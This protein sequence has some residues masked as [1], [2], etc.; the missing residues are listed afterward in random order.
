MTDRHFYEPA[1]GHGLSNDPLN[2]I[3]APRPI[4][5]IS[6]T[7]KA[8]VRKLAPYSFFNV[9]NYRPPLTQLS[10]S[11]LPVHTPEIRIGDICLPDER[12]VQHRMT[13]AYFSEVP[14]RAFAMPELCGLRV[15]KGATSR[16]TSTIAPRKYQTREGVTCCPFPGR[17]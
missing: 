13:F 10:F 1:N 17:F 6:T 16:A 3:V 4:G 7:S 15:G 12:V 8:G 14:I 2:A 5:W 11:V 9:L